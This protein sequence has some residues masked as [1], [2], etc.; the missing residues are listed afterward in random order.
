MS[1]YRRRNVRKFLDI[2][3]EHLPYHGQIS[4]PEDAVVQQMENGWWVWVPKPAQ[5]AQ[6]CLTDGWLSK[7]LGHASIKGCDYVLFDAD[8]EIDPELP[9]YRENSDK[10]IPAG[11]YMPTVAEGR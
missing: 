6:M 8:A 10:P 1:L 7:I 11:I 4:W 3:T 5:I 2:S 9:T